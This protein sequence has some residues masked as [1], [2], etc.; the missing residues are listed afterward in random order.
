MTSSLHNELSKLA[1]ETCCLYDVEISQQELKNLEKH[2]HE[3][4]KERPEE[5]TVINLSGESSSSKL[6]NIQFRI[7]DFILE[8]IET[9]QA[10]IGSGGNLLPLSLLAIRYV[11]KIK[12]LSRIPIS[13]RE[14][15]V[16]IAVYRLYIENELITVDNLFA[17]EHNSY[18]KD[19]IMD[20]IAALTK[21]GCVEY[22]EDSIEL[23]EP[24]RV[25][26]A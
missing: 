2:V 15:S 3:I 5:V 1:S 8:T 21:L 20:A 4:E 16:L 17:Q 11:Q 12:D 23:V 6:P 9:L 14:A 13:K 25:I 10:V 26:S 19:Q 24:I 7:G 22:G 18:S